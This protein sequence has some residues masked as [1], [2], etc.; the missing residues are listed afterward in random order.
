[1]L[2]GEY[3]F[4]IRDTDTGRVLQRGVL[5]A[6]GGKLVVP[7]VETRSD[8]AVKLQHQGATHP[9][10]LPKADLLDLEERLP[11]RRPARGE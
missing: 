5:T 11:A 1:M 4:S 3:N 6:E 9:R 8:V 2:P 7:L 10:L